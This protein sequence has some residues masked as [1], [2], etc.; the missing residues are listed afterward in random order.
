MNI[1]IV[2]EQDLKEVREFSHAANANEKAKEVCL[3]CSGNS[4]ESS[5]AIMEFYTISP[6]VRV[7][8]GISST[9]KLHKFLSGS[10]CQNVFTYK[11]KPR[12]RKKW[13][14]ENKLGEYLGR[15]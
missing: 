7:T 2:F 15:W 9:Q 10:L 8:K 1:C 4:W 5:M 14:T 3:S 11:G 12:D 13:D 6:S